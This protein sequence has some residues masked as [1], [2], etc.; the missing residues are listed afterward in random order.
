MIL[1]PSSNRDNGVLTLIYSF[2]MPAFIFLNGV[3][4][5]NASLMKAL[6]FGAIYL[7]VQVIYI[8]VVHMTSYPWIV[9][10]HIVVTP[11]FHV[12]YLLS[13]T[14][15]YFLAI[16]IKRFS[17]NRRIVVAVSVLAALLIRYTNFNIDGNF[18]SYMRTIV[19][20]PYFILGFHVTRDDLSKLRAKTKKYK[21]LALLISS[22][23]ILFN[24]LY[25]A[26]R[27][28]VWMKMFFGYVNCTQ[29]NQNYFVFFLKEIAQS[30]VSAIF[31]VI[32]LI[33]I[34]NGRGILNY[35]GRHTLFIFICHPLI[36]FIVY[37]HIERNNIGDF[38]AIIL[39]IVLTMISIAFSLFLEN[40]CLRL[41][42]LVHQ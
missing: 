42:T 5:K 22:F 4:S 26:P 28:A 12:W 27:S 1:T 6:R 39:A 2:H 19:F 33:L 23:L 38:S 18:F 8:L 24:Y 34:P 15:W 30:F 25:F 29:L 31:I 36:Y 35:L 21:G 40:I 9:E 14:F 32:L 13:L 3:F 20:A 7:I 16:L 17:I 10:T 37:N 41:R 11:I